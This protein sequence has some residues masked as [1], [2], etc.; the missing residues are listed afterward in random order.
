M[1]PTDSELMQRWRQGDS[2]AFETLVRR[3]EQRVANLLRRLL[4]FSDQVPDLCQEV[5]FKVFQARQHYRENGHFATWLYRIVLNTAR[6]AGRRQRRQLAVV[7]NPEPVDPAQLPGAKC[8][9]KET[10]QLVGRALA[11]LPKPLREVLVLH[12]Y[13]NLN[14]EQIARLTGIP[15]STLKS[16]FAAGLNRLRSRL[17]QLG[18]NPEEMQ[19]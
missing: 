4:G 17:Q 8:E 16:R 15:A 1:G 11:E 2:L 5:F 14:F 9:Q 13:E 12:H 6:D 18:W 10:T 19:S 7:E 3:W